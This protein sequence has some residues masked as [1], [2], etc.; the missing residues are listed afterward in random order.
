MNIGKHRIEYSKLLVS[1]ITLT[2]F[3]GLIVGV[4]VV[5]SNPSELSTL[6]MFIGG[7]VGVTIPFYVWKA[8]SE[9]ILK[10]KQEIRKMYQQEPDLEIDLYNNDD[11]NEDDNN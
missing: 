4:Y 11:E 7:V 8:K 1:I 3:V 9:N 10:I 2:Y 5:I 6:L